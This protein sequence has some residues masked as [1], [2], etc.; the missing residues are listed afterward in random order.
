MPPIGQ[1]ILF[2]YDFAPR[3][4]SFCNG[5]LVPVAQNRPLFEYLG[6]SYG[7]GA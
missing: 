4:F 6:T 5:H 1:I 2:P 3:N 7:G